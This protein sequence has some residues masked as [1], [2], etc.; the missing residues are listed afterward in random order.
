MTRVFTPRSDGSIGVRLNA[1]ERRL[2][3]GLV[4]VLESVGDADGDPAAL[5]LQAAAYPDDPALEAEWVAMIGA[6]LEADRSAD[7]RAFAASLGGLGATGSLSEEEAEAWLRVIGDTR[8]ALAARLGIDRDGWEEEGH[9]DPGR[10]MVMFLG[11]L[12]QELVE[13]LAGE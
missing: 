9:D 6:D 1:S 13:V 8:L 12:Q 10:A 7:R 4:A 5:G 3:A 11:Y 2:L